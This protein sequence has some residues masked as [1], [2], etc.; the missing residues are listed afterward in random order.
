MRD[1]LS[2]HAAIHCDI[3]LTVPS[4]KHKSVTFRN[5]KKINI[6]DFKQDLGD[7]FRNQAGEVDLCDLIDQYNETIGKILD[8]HAPEKT[9]KVN[10]STRP[11][12]PWYTDELLGMGITKD[13]AID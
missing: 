9:R 2:D 5:L 11:I 4:P 12:Q 3:N 6:T 13:F 10:L 8:K 7:A 1:M